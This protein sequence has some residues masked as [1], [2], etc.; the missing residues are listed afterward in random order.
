[1]APVE[2]VIV[3]FL[4]AFQ[5]FFSKPS[6]VLFDMIVRTFLTRLCADA[7]LVQAWRWMQGLKHWTNLHRFAKNYKWFPIMAANALLRWFIRRR[8]LG[9]LYFVADSTDVE[10]YSH[11]LPG[12]FKLWITKLRRYGWAQRWMVIGLLIPCDP[13]L[14]SLVCC[15]LLPL[16]WNREVKQT[17]LLREALTFFD[18]PAS[19]RCYLIVDAAL[20]SVIPEGWHIVTRLRGD[21][22]LF[23]FPPARKKGQ[24]GRPRKKGKQRDARRTF[25]RA[26]DAKV[27][28]YRGDKVKVVARRWLVRQWDYR[29]AFVLICRPLRHPDWAPIILATTDLA[30]TPQKLLNLYAARLEI[31]ALFQCVKTSGGFG[32]YRGKHQESHERVAQ[33]VLLGHTLRQ[34]I[35]LDAELPQA[36]LRE[37]WRKSDDR[38]K[39]T[40]GQ[41]RRLLMAEHL[42]QILLRF[43][44]EK[45]K[46]RIIHD[47][48]EHMLKTLAQIL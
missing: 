26:R 16:L 25:E 15:G 8:H 17:N 38:E 12:V 20:S 24:R 37:D 5:P 19:V 45:T 21:A 30:M 7:S 43:I 2:V 42:A 18:L 4:A 33:L 41:L 11:K 23:D 36:D 10:R 44:S 40:L 28:D 35:L 3:E 27:L 22:A 14:R 48:K 9:E 31:E 1:M 47:F 29:P 13:A 6:F 46:V 39:L 32:K 34:V